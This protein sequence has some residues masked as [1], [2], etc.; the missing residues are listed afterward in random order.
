PGGEEKYRENLATWE[1]KRDEL[2][3]ACEA[4]A[5]DLVVRQQ[6][7][8][9]PTAW[10][11]AVQ[12]ALAAGT[13]QA[14]ALASANNELAAVVTELARIGAQT[15]DV[16]E[17]RQTATAGLLGGPESGAA[18]TL[19]PLRL[20]TRWLDDG[21]YVRIYPDDLLVDTHDE[22]LTADETTWGTHYWAVGGGD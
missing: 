15:A 6:L 4:A 11:A 20:E 14:G 17:A 21:L 3:A 22:R 9:A 18:V 2:A 10:L 1:R 16:R 7:T 19:L 13:V 12:A 8:V 5:Q